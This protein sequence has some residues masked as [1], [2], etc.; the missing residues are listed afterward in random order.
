MTTKLWQSITKG[1]RNL[2]VL[3]LEQP[4][5]AQGCIY[6]ID[7]Q[8]KS[9]GFSQIWSHMQLLDCMP[10]PDTTGEVCMECYLVV[11]NL[12]ITARV[13]CEV[14]MV[15]KVNNT[16][17]VVGGGVPFGLKVCIGVACFVERKSVSLRVVMFCWDEG[18]VYH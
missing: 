4:Y 11:I 1:P 3:T 17:S 9:G 6:L 13:V 7:D 16:Y 18:Y 8:C 14:N 5:C 12:I 15:T 10:S 2:S